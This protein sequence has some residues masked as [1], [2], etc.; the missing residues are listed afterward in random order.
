MI[1]ACDKCNMQF[2]VKAKREQKEIDGQIIS[3]DYFECPYCFNMYTICFEDSS[4][5]YLRNK[6]EEKTKLLNDVNNKKQYKSIIRDITKL[7]KSTKKKMKILQAKFEKE[8][9]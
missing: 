9:K 5:I 6:I 3:H 8:K 2:E 1:V 4:V 7:K